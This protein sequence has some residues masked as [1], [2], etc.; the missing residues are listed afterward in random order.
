[1][2][3]G[4]MFHPGAAAFHE[5][6]H[7]T[8]GGIFRI[9]GILGASHFLLRDHRKFSPAMATILVKEQDVFEES[10]WL[11]ETSRLAF[12][13]G[14]LAT[15]GAHHR[16]QRRLLNPV[17]ST[18]HIRSMIPLF[19]KITRQLRDVL[20][21]KVATGPQEIDVMDW[22]S[23][24]ALELISQGGF[25]YTFD[26]LNPEG[27]ENAFGTAIK[28]YI[29]NLSSLQ[30]FRSALPL[31]S[32]WPSRIR[33]FGAKFLPLPA[34]TRIIQVSDVMHENTKKVFD[35][36]KALLA[37]G[38]D[39]F[40]NQV[41][42]K[43]DI[44]SSLMRANLEA[45][46]AD[47]LAD[48]EI[49][50]QMTTFAFAATDTTSTALSRVLYLLAQ[51]P[52][53]QNKLREEL[54]EAYVAAMDS[55]LGY[56]ELEN[57]PLL[58]AICRETLRLHPPLNFAARVCRKDTSISLSRPV[59]TTEGIVSSVF[60]PAET[61]VFIGISNVNRDPDIWGADA[62]E[63]KP[64]RWL[65]P[66]PQSVAEAHIPGIYSNTMTFL[67]GGRSC[68][69]FKFSQLE[70]K[71]VLAQLVRCF[72]FSPSQAEVVWRFGSITTPSVKGSNKVVSQMPIVL[73]RV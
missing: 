9:T 7:R 63:W 3:Y 58:D 61:T 69:G 4:Q 22:F 48:E 46:Q 71:V 15:T 20:Q 62:S 5:E 65:S 11:L 37:N 70:M 55:E 19:H 54:S 56:D 31:V 66:L 25:G 34:L 30:G 32:R 52:D 33:R 29:P 38:D 2:N 26:S 27:T 39:E 40:V 35:E 43:K 1:G 16:K 24:L 51:H 8:F 42:E 50:G 64:E 73:E 14:L 21:A 36:K 45:A 10:T 49:L 6:L 12:G 53:V 59:Q 72:R 13:P 28:A 44:I 23:R 57:L 67:G 60:I 18:K 68:I 17:F 41:G 47:Q